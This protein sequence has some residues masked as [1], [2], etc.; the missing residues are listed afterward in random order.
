[1]RMRRPGVRS[2]HRSR[3]PSRLGHPGREAHGQHEAAARTC[4]GVS[5]C[6]GP[7]LPRIGRAPTVRWLRLKIRNCATATKGIP[8]TVCCVPNP[9]AGPPGPRCRHEGRASPWTW[10]RV[11]RGRLGYWRFGGALRDGGCRRSG[12]RSARRSHVTAS[13]VAPG[14]TIPVHRC[15]TSIGCGRRQ[16]MLVVLLNVRREPVTNRAPCWDT[17]RTAPTDVLTTWESGAVGGTGALPAR[18]NV[19]E[20]RGKSFVR[21]TGPLNGH[22]G[23]RQ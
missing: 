17:A 21:A 11:C 12:L 4:F 20:T 7:G 19:R 22:S 10:G 18:R 15:T 6:R 2:R 13:S 16:G 3:G 8:A 23:S 14:Y 1:M 9:C 5:V